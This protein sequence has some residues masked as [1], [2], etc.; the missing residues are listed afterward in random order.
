MSA[1]LL[2][3][4][5]MLELQLEWRSGLQPDC[6]GRERAVCSGLHFPNPWSESMVCFS[7]SAKLK[8]TFPS[9]FAVLWIRLCAGLSILAVT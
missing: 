8:Q 1:H 6:V 4:N 7:T 9:D 5:S 2:V 3:K